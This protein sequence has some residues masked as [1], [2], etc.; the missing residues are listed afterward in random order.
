[1]KRV[2]WLVGL[3]TLALAPAAQ[4]KGLNFTTPPDGVRVGEPIGIQYFVW[5]PPKRKNAPV[6]M[7]EGVRPLV[8]LRDM[9]SDRV[10]RVRMRASDLA[11]IADGVVRLPAH[12]PW[13]TTVRVGSRLE[14]PDEFG[15]FTVG[16]GFPVP[17]GPAK[18]AK[19]SGN[20]ED[21]FKW[22][23]LLLGAPLLARGV[24]W[25]RRAK[26]AVPRREG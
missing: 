26:A 3:L 12:G 24:A 20:E 9:K 8:T 2:V 6:T 23:P 17:P 21:G 16:T 7:I 25:T 13:R 1:M 14:G 19:A 5:G 4:A 22:A 10:V 15:A 11:G 18:A